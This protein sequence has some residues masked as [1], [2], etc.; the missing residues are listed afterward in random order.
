[1]FWFLFDI[2]DWNGVTELP[3]AAVPVEGL[4]EAEPFYHSLSMTI[5]RN[6]QVLRKLG[7]IRMIRI[8]RTFIIFFENLILQYPFSS[9]PILQLAVSEV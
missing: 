6:H 3:A 1:M 5:A 7:E 4:E 2:I 8:T 9:S